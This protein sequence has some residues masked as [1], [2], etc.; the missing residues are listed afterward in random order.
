MTAFYYRCRMTHPETLR[1]RIP[2]FPEL[3]FCRSGVGLVP[4]PKENDPG[5]AL[6][7][8]LSVVL[9]EEFGACSCAAFRRKKTCRHVRRLGELV[10]EFSKAAGG[11]SWQ[12]IFAA[13]L[14]RRLGE[15]L[16]EGNGQSCS[17]VRV[18]RSESGHP[19]A[20]AF[21]CSRGELLAKWNGAADILLRFLERIGK[22]PRSI[23]ASDRATLIHKLGLVLRT[24]EERYFNET[25]VKSR[26][27][28]FEESFYGRLAY[29]CFR[30]YGDRE[31]GFH[32]AIDLQSGEFT[33]KGLSQENEPVLQLVVPRRQVKAVLNLLA[34]EFPSQED[35]TIHPVPLRSIF[36]ISSTTQLDL[37]VRPVVEALQASGESRFYE[38]KDLARFRYGDLVYVQELG[39]LAQLER[40]GAERKFRAPVSMRLE[41]SQ[42]P[43]FVEE[44]RAEIE[45]G[46]LVLEEPLRQIKV[47]KDYDYMEIVPLAIKRSWYWLSIRYGFGNQEVSL[48]EI[49][50]ARRQGQAYLETAA[51]W[52][53]LNTPAFQAL[54]ML[55]DDERDLAKDGERIRLS[56]VDLLRLAAINRKPLE[57]RGQRAAILRR[58]LDLQPVE[59]YRAPSGLATPLRRY[60]ELGVDWLKFLYENG[61]A[62]L[63]CDEMGL[64][65]THQA[66]ALMLWLRERAKEPCL[67]VCP[68]TVISHWREKI[69]VHAPGLK[70]AVYH[71]LQR[72]LPSALNEADVLLTSYGVL[73]N[74]IDRLCK[75]PMAVALFDEIQNLK[76]RETLSYQA[77]CAIEARMKLGLTGTPVE[78]S[79]ED[80]KS[81]FDLILPGYLAE[82]PGRAH[83]ADSQPGL[84]A[85]ELDNLRRVIFPFVLRRS[86]EAVL[87]ELPEKI[88]DVRTCALSEDQIKLY[89]DTLSSKGAPLLAQLASGAERLPYIHIFAVLN[90]LKMICDHPALL[91]NKVEE[92]QKYESGKWDLFQELLFESLDSGQKVVVFSQYL[93]MIDMMQ[94]LLNELGI[95]FAALTGSTRDRG[96][97]IRRFNQDQDCRVF[98]GSLKAGG[99]GIDLVAGSVVLHYDRWWNAA[100]EEQATDRVH[101]IGQRRAVQ[102]FKLITEGTLEEKISAIIERKRHLMNTVV[103]EDD[104]HFSKI[105]SREELAGLLQPL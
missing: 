104:P 100:R 21:L 78:N 16:A 65:K 67:V 69:R 93:G 13:S 52:I 84:Q 14:W 38:E 98:L 36:K 6:C 20:T 12:E 42:I 17:T 97:V 34:K 11:R 57:V 102:V 73:R 70:A 51:G 15:A 62:G 24:P 72:D 5:M 87:E 58:L 60:Q 82:D 80:L 96:E 66:M 29:H 27:Q 45:A 7:V 71:G 92:Y 61:L 1:A 19:A 68:T 41:R 26:A 79:L 30:E 90:Y 81:L 59:P 95:G 103:R 8:S 3:E 2:V 37:E 83:P 44:H 105:F 35:L 18:C 55:A 33:L 9:D 4:N 76:N 63:L 23:A 89:R 91:L 101:R 88:E 94:R 86:K 99:T 43:G 77:A 56:S 50:K 74:D 48:G 25:G 40:P 31:I 22:A 49:L 85:S 64:G 47:L 46:E 39:V 28:A 54:A 75:V 32:P 53:D 10:S